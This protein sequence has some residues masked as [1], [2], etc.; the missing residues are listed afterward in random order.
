MSNGT[1]KKYPEY[2]EQQSLGRRL[3]PV[4]SEIDTGSSGTCPKHNRALNP[5]EK[6]HFFFSPLLY[7][8]NVSV[9]CFGGRVKYNAA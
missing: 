2:T 4:A 3:C 6:L 7:T 1:C 8:F 5:Q 9:M